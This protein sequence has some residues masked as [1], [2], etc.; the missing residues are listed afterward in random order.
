ML[1]ASCLAAGAPLSAPI[2]ASGLESDSPKDWTV[3]SAKR[4]ESGWQFSGGAVGD[5][6]EVWRPEA[7]SLWRVTG[8]PHCFNSHETSDP[9]KPWSR[10]GSREF[11]LQLSNGRAEILFVGKGG[12]KIEATPEKL[13][14]ASLSL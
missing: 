4:L 8:L 9:D 13:P 14:T 11:E 12:C 2:H 6:G 10:A 1:A 5:V 3:P 7:A